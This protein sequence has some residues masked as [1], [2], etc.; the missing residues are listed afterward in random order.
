MT[1]PAQSTTAAESGLTSFS[2]YG[3]NASHGVHL[4]WFA[5]AEEA[6]AYLDSGVAGEFGDGAYV[7]ADQD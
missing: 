7:A 4:G 6:Q 3:P 1:T 5:S 2:A